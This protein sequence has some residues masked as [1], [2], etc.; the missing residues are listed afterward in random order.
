[1]ILVKVMIKVH[2]RWMRKV[3]V[4]RVE[5]RWLYKEACGVHEKEAIVQGIKSSQAVDAWGDRGLRGRALMRGG[6]NNDPC[7]YHVNFLLI[8]GDRDEGRRR[9]K[10]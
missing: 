1:M 2:M 8:A 4:V 10:K 9:R 5:V 6:M 3:G 7:V